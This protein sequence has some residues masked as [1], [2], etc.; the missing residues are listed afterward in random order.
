MKKIIL[1]MIITLILVSN[2]IVLTAETVKNSFDKTE[3]YVLITKDTLNEIKMNKD[4][5]NENPLK[6]I[7]YGIVNV[8]L[9]SLFVYVIIRA[10]KGKNLIPDKNNDD[11]MDKY[12]K[13]V[14]EQ[15]KLFMKESEN[16]FR[17]LEIEIKSVNSVLLQ[18]VNS[19]KEV[20]ENN[21][22]INSEIINTMSK[23]GSTLEHVDKTIDRNNEI[24][25]ELKGKIN[26]H[27]K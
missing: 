1:L 7:T 27:F 23:M 26:G 21:N 9:I 11:S 16:N 6:T 8:F 4:D 24:I 3:D 19:L 10:F 15:A 18:T 25:Y 20:I 12:L 5:F 22:K 14:H 2:F 13:F 17:Q